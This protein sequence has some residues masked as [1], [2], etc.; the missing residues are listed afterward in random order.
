M[1]L[2]TKTLRQHNDDAKLRRLN[3]AKLKNRL[4]ITYIIRFRRRLNTTVQP[5]NPLITLLDKISIITEHLNNEL[6][7]IIIW[8][9]T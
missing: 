1:T 5:H 6:N 3:D 7:R 9:K 4:S 8:L 2:N